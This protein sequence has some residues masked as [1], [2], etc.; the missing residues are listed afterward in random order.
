MTP[1]IHYVDEMLENFIQIIWR[2][3]FRSGINAL[4]LQG[5]TVYVVLCVCC[6]D[7][8]YKAPRNQILTALAPMSLLSLHFVFEKI[9]EATN[10]Q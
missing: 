10:V 7:V 8:T 5:I 4:L 6:V 1:V 3:T 2:A 9:M